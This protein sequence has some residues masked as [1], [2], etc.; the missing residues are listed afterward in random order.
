MR[1][2]YAV[3]HLPPTHTGG[4]E[5]RALRTARWMS[6]QEHAVSLMAIEAIDRAEPAYQDAKEAGLVIRRLNF[7]AHAFPDRWR[8]Q[9]DNEVVEERVAAALAEFRPDV[10]HLIGGYLMTAGALRA[11]H[12]AG[13]PI[14]VT[15]TDFWFL[16]PRITLLCSDGS[17]CPRPPDDPLGCVRCLA[18]ESRRFRLP[19]RWLPGVTDLAWRAAGQRLPWRPVSAAQMQARRD[20]LHAALDWA[21]VLICPSRFLLDQYQQAGVAPHK[22]RLMRQGLVLPTKTASS[23]T[24]ARPAF[25]IGFLGQIKA[26]KGVDVLIEAASQLHAAGYPLTLALHGDT[27]TDPAYV[28]AL[29]RRF[30]AL[31]WLEWRGRY[32]DTE[33][34]QVLADLDVL[35]VPSRWYENSP[36]VILEAQ[37]AGVP[38][39]TTD[40]GGMSELVHNEVDGLLF[41]LNDAG[42]LARQLMRLVS[43]PS[44]LRRLRDQAPAVKPLDEEMQALEAIY[45]E[46]TAPGGGPTTS[47]ASRIGEGSPKRG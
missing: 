2:L 46:L 32:A 39:V 11:A 23:E 47:A 7:D 43:E 10:F 28:R 25:T 33:V 17:L 36:N 6:G 16:C 34:W 37:A 20:S 19:A 31:P 26:H 35:V 1:L 3:H 45:D 12:R 27:Q 4:A 14:V 21:S 41:R 9:Y 13:V 18:Q 15:L 38:V 8:W 29:K 42:D 24:A 40:L 44:L 22:L 5:S 30:G